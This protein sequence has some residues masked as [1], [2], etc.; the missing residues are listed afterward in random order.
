MVRFYAPKR[1]H[2]ASMRRLVSA[3]AVLAVLVGCGDK[4]SSQSSIV[5]EPPKNLPPAEKLYE[6]L[7]SGLFQIDAGVASIE[8]ALQEAKTSDAST[9]DLKQSLEDIQASIDSAGDILSEEA[10]EPAKKDDAIPK[11][12]E[13]RK[14]LIDL[15]NDALHDLRDARGIVDSLAGENDEG[16]LEPVGLKIDT[17]M[18][19]LRGALEALGGKEE[20]EA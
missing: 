6:Q 4:A 11:A 1:V 5:V 18:T 15:T 3:L 16:P 12:E 17:A 7:R 8:A 13:R 2:C 14:K 9:A 19:D 20:V 10:V